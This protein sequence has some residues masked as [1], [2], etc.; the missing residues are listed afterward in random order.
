MPI[1]ST[2]SKSARLTSST[3]TA[4]TQAEIYASMSDD[5]LIEAYYDWENEEYP[6]DLVFRDQRRLLTA[7]L[8]ERGYSIIDNII[9]K[10]IFKL[11]AGITVDK[12]ALENMMKYYNDNQNISS[13]VD[14]GGICIFAFEGL[15]NYDGYGI[16]EYHPI[17]QRTVKESGEDI[18]RG[19]RY[20]AMF[21]VTK[22]QD[23]V[24]TTANASTLPDNPYGSAVIKDGVYDLGG[25][26]HQGLYPAL[27]LYDYGTKSSTVPASYK[28]NSSKTTA[29]GVNIHTAPDAACSTWSTACQ[30][31]MTKDYIDFAISTGS[32][33]SSDEVGKFLGGMEIDNS[34][35]WYGR[36]DEKISYEGN[37]YSYED[38]LKKLDYQYTEWA[39]IENM[40]YI[41]DRELMPKDQ[42]KL[43][44]D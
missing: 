1:T 43:F 23:V 17:N 13:I 28:N 3:K 19:G 7:E 39:Q 30:I 26:K 29:E 11:K 31:I 35:Q 18:V 42:K 36:N 22:G 27:Q 2:G 44:F 34:N 6:N 9:T 15:G 25:R 38:L 5:E 40:L 4:I 8:S 12:R 10:N 41:V 14:N 16:K 33:S 21:V 32:I 20:G 37:R 24:F